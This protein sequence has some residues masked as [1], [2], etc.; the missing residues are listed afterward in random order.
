[1]RILQ[2]SPSLPVDV[3]AQAVSLSEHGRLARLYTST[4][5]NGR[6]V[7][8]RLL[9]R[10]MSR[11]KVRIRGGEL[12]GMISSDVH[13]R[14]RRL[15]GGSAIECADERFRQVDLA[16]SRHVSHR[17]GAVLCREDAAELTFENARKCD[18]VRIYDL[19]I[20]HYA[21]TQR[22]MSEE[23]E[24][25]PEL[26]ASFS[27]AEEYAER[28]TTRKDRELRL[29]DHIL[30]P[31]RFVKRSLIAAG[32]GEERVRVLPFACEADWPGASDAARERIVLAVGQI[33][34]RKG[35]HR[36]L[37][38]WK[39]M[40]AYRTHTLRL[41]GDM[42]LPESYLARFRGLYEHVPS[43]SRARLV[44]EYAAASVFVSNSMSE[45]LS[46][47]IPEAVSV[48]TPIVASLNTG[49]D[50]IISD[51]EE[52]LLVE[53]GDDDAL[54]DRIDRLLSSDTLRAAMEAKARERARRRTWWHY[55]RE[56]IDWIDS[57]T[58]G[59]GSRTPPRD[60]S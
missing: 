55:S 12:R 46:I 49:A 30:C 13:Q 24:H 31:S 38:V 1:M 20:A 27:L 5:S 8:G 2:V 45:G 16:A 34:V 60:Q 25:Y 42:R 6:D 17:L 54:A 29:A 9:G 52:G 59:R 57:V 4:A 51:G 47:V 10:W 58:V 7:T 15:T 22:L 44:R 37:K 3:C 43:L 26:E 35:A 23:A 11:R 33:S 21:Y 19:P 41:I 48:G 28:R 14:L 39:D 18:V 40:G 32:C 36:L 50:E 56:F 53:Y